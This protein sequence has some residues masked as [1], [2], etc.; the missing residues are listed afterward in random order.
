MFV[1]INLR[2][3]VRIG[4]PNWHIDGR[5]SV[6]RASYLVMLFKRQ[7]FSAATVRETLKRIL[8]TVLLT[9]SFFVYR[10]IC[11]Y[12]NCPREDH[13][14]MAASNVDKS[15]WN[16]R[17][18]NDVHSGHYFGSGNDNDS[19]CATEEFAWTPP[20][21]TLEMVRPFTL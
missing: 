11:R 13:C 9:N 2:I 10:K 18:G 14:I 7:L 3:F 5:D 8:F 6:P 12:C 16:S 20:G 17:A 19:G 15:Q 4:D 21:L 1:I